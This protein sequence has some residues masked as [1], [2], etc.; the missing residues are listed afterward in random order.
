M[1]K[2]CEVCR[3]ACCESMVIDLVNEPRVDEWLLVRGKPLTKFRVEVETVCPSLSNGRCSRYEYR[4][5]ACQVF[6]VGGELCKETVIRRRKNWE[7][8]FNNF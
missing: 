3:G 7:E 5:K 6:E 1:S 8:I 2:A 4:P